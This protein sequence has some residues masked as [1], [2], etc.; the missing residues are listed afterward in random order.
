MTKNET[1]EDG[2]E[3][4]A[5]GTA[6]TALEEE[7]R[8]FEQL[9]ALARK[10]DLTSERNLEKAAKATQEAAESQ[11]RVADH[12]RKLV[13]AIAT[14]RDRQQAVAEAI[15]LR[16]TELQSRRAE[17]DAVLQDFSALGQEAAGINALVG[18]VSIPKAAGAPEP[19]ALGE[20]VTRL[21]EIQSKMGHVVERAQALAQSAHA[22]DMVDIAQQAESLQKQV[23][24][25]RNKLNLL[26]EKLSARA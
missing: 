4:S 7:L 10:I 16:A 15:Q 19:N 11:L 2:A 1:I 18:Q 12:V 14:A 17:F 21:Q 9:A 5:L 13:S 24:A 25:S 23:H 3:G 22:K 26:L 6:A 20:T 8:K